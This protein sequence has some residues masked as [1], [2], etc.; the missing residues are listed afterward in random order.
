MASPEPATAAVTGLTIAGILAATPLGVSVETIALGMGFAIVGLFGRLAFDIQKGIEAGDK[1]RLSTAIGWAG[2]GLIGA[3]FIAV[4][5]IVLLRAIGAQTDAATV[6]GLLFLG[7][8][9]PKGVTW[10]MGLVAD[11]V[12]SRLPKGTVAP[13]KP[14]E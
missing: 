7:F 4:V 2:A 9:G 1:V 11:F 3:P 5:W 14:G 12:G 6:I 8:S 10:V 13:P